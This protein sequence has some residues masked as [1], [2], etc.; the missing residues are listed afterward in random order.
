MPQETH[1]VSSLTSHETPNLC[2]QYP[3]PIISD[4]PLSQPEQAL[5]ERNRQLQLLNRVGQLFNSTQCLDAIL[6]IVLEEVRRLLDVAIC[7]IWLVDGET[8]NLVCQQATDPKSDVMR[9]WQLAAG[10]GLA[11]WVTST[12]NSLIVPDAQVDDRHTRE[13]D[14]VTGLVTQSVLASPLFV[15]DQVVGVLEV[16]DERSNRF[17]S[18]HLALLE[19][20]AASAASAIENARLIRTLREQWTL[21]EALVSAV[22]I[23]NSTLEIEDVLDRILAQVQRVVPGDTFN[24]MMLQGDVL[25]IVRA[26]GYKEVGISGLTPPKT[27]PLNMYPSFPRMMETRDSIVIQDTTSCADWKPKRGREWRLSYV[28]APILL[29]GT[30]VGFLNVNG[31]QP[32]Q[33]NGADAQR[34]KAFA[35]YAAAAI[36]NARLYRNAKQRVTEL[37]L[38]RRTSLQLTSSLNL[39]AVLKG[40]V[41]SALAL[42]NATD[43]HIYLYDEGSRTFT[44][45]AALWEDGRRDAAVEAP[46]SDG[47]TAT[48]AKKMLPIIINNAA[49]DPLYSTPKASQW[50]VKAVAGFPLMRAGRVVGVFTIAFTKPHTFS[51]DELRVLG[52]LADQ[53]AIAI[54]NARLVGGLEKEVAARTAEIRHEKEKS[55]AILRSVGEA[56][57]MLDLNG[58]IQYVNDAFTNLTGYQSYGAIGRQ[59]SFLLPQETPDRVQAVRLENLAEGEIWNQETSFKRKDGTVYDAACAIAPMHDADGKLVGYV[60]SHRDISRQKELERT[61]SRFMTLVSHQLRTPVT[62]IKLYAQMLQHQGGAGK[63]DRYLQVLREQADRLAE[64]VESILE[65]TALDSG[66]GHSSW[67]PQVLSS[68]IHNVSARFQDL[69]G[70]AGLTLIVNPI[71]QEIP[72]VNGDATRLSQ[73]LDEV[74]QNAMQFTPS[75]GTVV[76]SMEV[77]IDRPRPWVKI[78]VQDSGPGIPL[79]E[80]DKVFDRFFRGRLAESGHIPGTGLGL[81]IVQEILRIHGGR[82][83]TESSGIPGEGS[84][85]TLWLPATPQPS[86]EI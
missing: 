56:I 54:V 77:T 37:D 28:G 81:S 23:I 31:T 19:P 75:G 29:D 73:A 78:S 59:A 34:L 41:E 3:D 30:V 53:A 50:K 38:L 46:R 68:L 25:N 83:T 48:V 11:G 13:L 70:A 69:A 18:T 7:S 63:T 52:L 79:D 65:M 64:L 80:Q 5:H 45:G 32:R 1:G 72:P 35:S 61:R 39:S 27:V 12:G 40:I 86:P 14:A 74:V 49:S 4:T 76:I 33:F 84:T 21:A 85:I 43:C 20:L 57:A 9:G 24:V 62:N 36:R 60:S 6:D 82:V 16:I 2:Q 15:R 55:E 51:E 22:A 71:P 47:L 26:R 8:A 67:R 42:I 44:F 17:D 10:T 58:R 66:Q